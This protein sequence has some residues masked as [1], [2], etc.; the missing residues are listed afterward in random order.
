ML[1]RPNGVTGTV[2]GDF[3]AEFRNVAKSYDG[4]VDVVRDFELKIRRGEFLTL[5]GPSGAGK[6]TILMMLAGFEDPSR[7]DIFLDGNDLTRIPA[8]KRNM[9]VVFQSYALFPHRTVAENVAYP[10][11]QRRIA[12]T[13]RARRVAAAIAMVELDGL[14]RRRP[15]QL[16]GGQ[17][18]RVALARALVFEPSL[19][20][21]DEP[22]GAL[23][24][25]LRDQMQVEIKRLHHACGI[26]FVYVTHDQ[27]E[28]L[29][30]SD[31]V[32]ILNDG[33]VQQVG[34]PE[35]VYE[36]PD[37]AFVAD[38][39]GENNTFPGTVEHA[40]ND[41]CVVRLHS[42]HRVEARPRDVFAAGSPVLVSIRPERVVVEALS[43]DDES[44]FA[45]S[46]TDLL[47]HGDHLRIGVA[48]DGLG[49]VVA[50]AVKDPDGP[51][52]REGARVALRW[53][54]KFCSALDLAPTPSD[55]ASDAIR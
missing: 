40:G 34:T 8:F 11:V 36:A 12:K 49:T 39:I 28:A 26:T 24:K 9:G 37:N 27:D 31:R 14:E 51:P 25:K 19:V 54:P 18:Q 55:P 35:Q 32:V 23:D 47:F 44:D 52:M 53:H 38:F 20:L 15:S 10:L 6:T 2:P 17:Q 43:A 4:H 33:V 3:V 5:L 16:S 21:L 45:G 7:G 46:V 1:H 42:G 29:A 30:M 22:L 41:V 50:K 13:E 48:V